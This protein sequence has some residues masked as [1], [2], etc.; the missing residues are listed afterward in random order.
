MRGGVFYFCN[1][2]RRY[3]MKRGIKLGGFLI[4]VTLTLAPISSDAFNPLAHI[5]IADI[6]CPDCSPKIDYY[7]GSIAPDIAWSIADPGLRLALGNDTHNRDLSS[8]ARGSTQ[9]AFAKG[10]LT[11]SE[12]ELTKGADYFAHIAYSRIPHMNPTEPGYVIEKAY[13]L[14]PELVELGLPDNEQTLY[15]A[16]Y[17]I[18]ATIDLLLKYNNDHT[19]PGKLLFANLFRSWED[20]NLMMRVFVWRWWDKSTDWW[21][22]ATAEFAFRQLINRYAA[23]LIL[24]PPDDEIAL[25]ELGV[26]LA[27]EMYGLVIDPKELRT[28]ILPAAIEICEDDYYDVIKEAVEA[29]SSP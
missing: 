29:I 25:S 10:W 20:R 11:H 24:S 8:F 28:E 2:E 1:K 22:L 9:E 23:A 7:Y 18:E 16:H 21:T 12:N 5:H 19:L 3:K 27:M 13:L 4:I 15:F 6:A 14:V 26:A 17:I